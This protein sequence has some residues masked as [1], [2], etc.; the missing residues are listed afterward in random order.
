MR[1]TSDLSEI[2]DPFKISTIEP[3]QILVDKYWR[4]IK[5]LQNQKKYVSTY[6]GESGDKK[7]RR[8][9]GEIPHERFYPWS[10]VFRMW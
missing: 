8:Y 7:T 6:I 9:L 4:G 1:V 2:W 10:H 3:L 5:L